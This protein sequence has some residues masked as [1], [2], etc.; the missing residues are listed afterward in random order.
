MLATLK[1]RD[2]AL[3][4]FGGLIS[5]MGDWA[6]FAALPFYAYEQTGSAFASGAV[7]TAL[8]VPGLLIATVAGVFVDRWDRRRTM[9]AAN[10]LQQSVE[11]QYLGRVFGA[12]S[13]TTD[14]MFFVGSLSAGALA[15]LAGVV[16]LLIA[17]AL[18]YCA[19]GLLVPVLLGRSRMGSQEG[20]ARK[21]GRD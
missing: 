8:T 5:M 3:L 12:F 13:A 6:M 19:A 4:W 20:Q 17:S 14:L 11:D 16:P 1:Q 10:L 7:L 15:D 18:M 21:D 9:V 2:F